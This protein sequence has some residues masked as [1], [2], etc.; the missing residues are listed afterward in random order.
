[1][2][3]LLSTMAGARKFAPL[4][5]GAAGNTHLPEL[6]GIV[7]DVDGTLCKPQNYMFGEMR[8][9]LSI[10]KEVDILEHIYSL[11]TPEDREKAMESIRDIERTAM[12]KQQAQ[13]G[14]VELMSYIDSK[15][16]PKG[17]CTR[18]FDMP[19][20][21]LLT[22]FLSTVKPFHPIITR[23]FRPPKPD[24][25][26]ILHIARSWGL[27]RLAPAG[28]TEGELKKVFMADSAEVKSEIVDSGNNGVA[29]LD[30][31][32]QKWQGN[33][34]GLIMVGDSIDDMTAG[35]RAGAATVLLVN[36]ANEHLASHEHTDLVINRLDE[37]IGHLEEGFT[38]RQI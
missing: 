35:R 33:A 27:V 32:G 5:E 37:L 14:L 26:G 15:S 4:K 31:E 30:G 23:E 13:P 18:N 12:S 6:K 8:N 34:S 25:A 17:I 16:L 24:P 10:S 3:R 22:K 7:F 9:A 2:R 20:D 29:E 21:H 19:V 28:G 36:P 38:G 11:P 1:M